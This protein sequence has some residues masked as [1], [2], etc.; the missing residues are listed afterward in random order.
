M[1]LYQPSNIIPSSFAG[2]GGGVV[3]VNDNVSI[4]WQVNGSSPLLQEIIYIYENN[5]ASTLV[6]TFTSSVHNGFFGTD[7]LGNIQRYVFEPGVTWA[8]VGLTNGNSYK[9]KIR[10]RYPAGESTAYVDQIS[11]SVFITR[12]APTL[13]ITPAAGTLTSVQQTFAAHYSQAQDD[14]IEWVRWVLSDGNGNV[15]DDTGTIYTGKLG[16]SYNGFFDGVTYTLSCTVETSSGATKTVT[17]TYACS[18]TSSAASGGIAT[19]CNP[20]DSVTLSW[21]AGADIQGTPSAEDYGSIVDGV[22]HLAASRSITWNQVN[23]ESMSFSSPYAFAWRGQIG[24][25]STSQQTIN[26][27]TWTKISDPTQT[28]TTSNTVTVSNLTLTKPYTGTGTHQ[29]SVPAT[30]YTL[31]NDSPT[32]HVT[33][34]WDG[35]KYSG[36]ALYDPGYVINEIP[37]IW[38]GNID[39]IE[40]TGVTHTA[41]YVHMSG[42]SANLS[43]NFTVA[44]QVYSGSGSY[45]PAEGGVSGPTV[46]ST[47]AKEAF[48]SMSGNTIVVAV[49]AASSGTYTVNVSYSYTYAGNDSYSGSTSGTLSSSLGTLTSATVTSTTGTGGASVSTSGNNYTVAIRNNSASSCT[50][51]V[52]LSYKNVSSGDEAYRSI[53]T[54]TVPNAISATVISTTATKAIISE[55]G[56]GIYTLTMYYSS[57]TSRTATVNFTVT[58]IVP[59]DSLLELNSGVFKLYNTEDQILFKYDNLDSFLQFVMPSN[60]YYC[61]AIIKTGT[62][63]SG[64]FEVHFYDYENNEIRSDSWTAADM[65]ETENPITSVKLTGE[66]YC[67]YVYITS[68]VSYQF[69]TTGAPGWNGSTLFNAS[70]AENLQAGTLS[71]SD[72]LSVAIYRK[73]GTALTPLG[74]YDSTVSTIRDYGIRSQGEYQ[75]ILYYISDDT[76]SVGMLSDEICK[77]FR[78]FTLIEAT[79]D[80]DDQSVYHPVSVWRFRNN[81]EAGAVSNGNNPAMLENFTKYPLWQP[82]SQAPKSGTLTALLSFFSE[83]EYIRETAADMERLYALSQSVNPLFLRDMK[84]N[85][86]MVRLSGPISQTVNYKTGVM[87]VTVSVPWVEIGDAQDV[88]IITIGG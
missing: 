38:S 57:A 34:S 46:S 62:Y 82:S 20:D 85:L 31:V 1:A 26:S 19:S 43:A 30:N 61:L 9:L 73:E 71:S 67:D 50:A 78:Q 28:G 52:S 4:S 58:S 53:V 27:G 41:F 54:V 10:Q 79:Q 64:T 63:P 49:N 17:N 84:G 12:T 66:Q 11:A 59:H 29:F 40:Y 45:T 21:A 76:Y 18:Y 60:T 88:K 48:T 80:T 16:Y 24:T 6:H 81:I 68:D 47:T 44:L 77:Q 86:Y 35:S 14:E 5:A 55:T 83:G 75:Y 3:D 33:G 32:I 36:V 25:T 56:G 51:T 69:P 37:S 42:S 7:A 15:I 74:V 70:F 72:S 13:S 39:Y 8:S 23:G 2:I 22:L 87:E 65:Y